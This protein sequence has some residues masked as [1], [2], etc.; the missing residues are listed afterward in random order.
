MK[1]FFSPSACSFAPHIALAELGIKYELESVNL[2]TKQC[3]SGD[4]MKINPKGSVPALKMDNGE[5]LTEVAVILQYLADQK[6]EKNLIPKAGTPE[7]Y[8]CQEWLNFIATE[9]H[10]GMS[11]LFSADRFITNKEGNQQYR[12][13]VKALF[14]KKMNILSTQLQKN[15]YLMGS[16]FTVADAYL[17]TVLNWTKHLQL[18]LTPWPSLLGFMERMQTRPAVATALK[19]EGL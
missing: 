7:R 10:K 6:P 9:V 8:R 19:E 13:M 15:N 2:G 3:A 4:Y 1:L 14:E 5:V 12:G 17:F 11:G 16:Q 18:D